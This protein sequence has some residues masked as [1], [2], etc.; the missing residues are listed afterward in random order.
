MLK[1]NEDLS[2]LHGHNYHLAKEHSTP[3]GEW[4]IYTNGTKRYAQEIFICGK[5]LSHLLDMAADITRAD[6]I[7]DVIDKVEEAG[8]NK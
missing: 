7:R 6:T 3:K 4:V 8:S 5:T 2:A 1:I